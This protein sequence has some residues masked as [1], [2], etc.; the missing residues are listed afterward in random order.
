MMKKT[1]GGR[2]TARGRI[3][4]AA[5]CVA[6]PA[7]A[8]PAAAVDDFERA[9]AGIASSAAVT[10]SL[11]EAAEGSTTGKALSIA[12]PFPHTPWVECHYQQSRAVPGLEQPGNVAI[13]ME[14]WLPA[15]TSV[16]HISLSLVDAGD[17]TFMWMTKLPPSTTAGWRTVEVPI[18]TQNPA[19]HWGGTNDG[20]IDYPLKLNGYAVV[21]AN[22]KVPAGRV[23]IDQVRADPIPSAILET[24]R[25]PSLV[26]ATGNAKCDLVISSP[27]THPISL[28]MKGT[29]TDFA[30]TAS[31]VAGSVTI[32][33]GGKGRIPLSLGD[34]KGM[35]EYK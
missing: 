18:D 10:V 29:L 11:I 32:P 2:S 30:G 34:R 4:A 8:V 25:F 1:L 17:E 12:W 28:M 14:A 24:D 6:G 26:N 21:F 16:S 7:F 31:E 22:D 3:I 5:L 15:S 35:S 23:L 19:G 20:R 27:E 13:R 33:A 9:E